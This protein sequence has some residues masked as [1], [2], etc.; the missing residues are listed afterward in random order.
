M[1]LL[2]ASGGAHTCPKSGKL[3]PPPPPPSSTQS[4]TVTDLSPIHTSSRTTEFKAKL[5]FFQYTCLLSFQKASLAINLCFN[6]FFGIPPP[7][8]FVPSLVYL[9]TWNIVLAE[10]DKINL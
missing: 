9:P 3:L 7:D 8:R 6:L 2:F 5:R 10:A 1:G 4:Q